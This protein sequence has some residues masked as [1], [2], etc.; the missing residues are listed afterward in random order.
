MRVSRISILVGLALVVTVSS[1]CFLLAEVKS[2][3]LFDEAIQAVDSGRPTL[4]QEKLRE[5]LK[6]YPDNYPA[7][8]VLGQLESEELGGGDQGLRR[9]NAA[10]LLMKAAV[11][12]PLRAEAFLA[13]AQLYYSSGYVAKGDEAAKMAVAA[14]PYSY[15]AFCLLGQ[16]YEDSGNFTEAA[17]T[18]SRGLEHYGM[19]PYLTERRYLAATRG[20]LT[21]EKFITVPSGTGKPWSIFVRQ[22]PDFYLMAD[23]SQAAGK[24]PNAASHYSLPLFRFNSCKR[25]TVPTRRYKDLYEA[26]VKASL[27]DPGLYKPVRAELDRIRKEA[28]KAISKE[29]GDKA[30][31]KAL[32]SWL[33]KNVLKTYDRRRGV[34]ADS[35]LKKK[36]YVSLN[37][38]IL[39]TLIARE[40]GLKVDGSLL[41]G[42]FF[43]TVDDGLRK[44][45]VELSAEARLGLPQEKGFDVL[46]WDQFR[47]LTQLSKDHGVQTG[48]GSRMLGSLDPTRLTAYQFLST[49]D[50]N[51]ARI[52]DEFKDETEYKKS[53]QEAIL[54][55]RRELASRLSAIQDRYRREP[56]KLESLSQRTKEKFKA[57]RRK[58]ELE[59]GIINQ[60]LRKAKAKYFIETGLA[61]LRNAKAMAPRVDEFIDREE[62]A[63]DLLAS[64]D[65]G[66]AMNSMMDRQRRRNEFFRQLSENLLNLQIEERVS[67][68]ASAAATRV[69]EA[70]RR[71]N[72]ELA[73]IDAEEKRS[74][75]SEKDDWL[76]AITRLDKVV[77]ELPCSQRLKRSLES[78]CWTAVR[79]AEKNKD[80]LTADQVVRTGLARL[81]NSD[82]ARYYRDRESGNL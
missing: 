58:E 77:E 81:P 70:I 10:Q 82:F 1:P 63:L 38:S 22:Y 27:T 76:N 5:L 54:R 64:V 78:L 65:V 16:R 79:L 74:W 40:A 19:D 47:L 60:R 20:G 24:I 68:K 75:K 15:E 46:W 6:Q 11:L 2:G 28:L 26:F 57:E 8:V 61:L 51:L 56:N 29:H 3:A 72:A 12:Q 55:N 18:Y 71:I 41:P 33:K 9:L 36:R 52:E 32:Y 59:I 42:H 37:A 69:Q 14:N 30:K 25:E 43:A 53:L 73:A 17:K 23:Y 44:I 62:Q 67:G 31:A 4:A 45:P 50:H 35:L 7:L 48:A 13:L 66:P 34:L 49:N 21:P 80:N 39:Y